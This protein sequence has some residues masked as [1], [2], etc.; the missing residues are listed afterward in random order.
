MWQDQT[1]TSSKRTSSPTN[2][3]HWII[4]SFTCTLYGPS[5]NTSGHY[6][7]SQVLRDF[8]LATYQFECGALT[9]RAICN[10]LYCLWLSDRGL[11]RDFWRNS[12]IVKVILK[13]RRPLNV[14][15]T[16]SKLEPASVSFRTFPF[17]F[18]T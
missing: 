11:G 12:R 9:Y 14:G 6:K 13:Q 1:W 5:Y 4:T 15:C 17:W 16:V 8:E 3:Y 18:R 10:T 7:P 2:V